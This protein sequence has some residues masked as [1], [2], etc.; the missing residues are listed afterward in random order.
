MGVTR[1]FFDMTANGSPVGRIIMELRDDVG[2]K[3]VSGPCHTRSARGAC[4]SSIAINNL[5]GWW[6]AHLPSRIQMSTP[7][8][9][10]LPEEDWWINWSTESETL[11]ASTSG[12]QLQTLSQ[13]Q[14]NRMWH[15]TGKLYHWDCWT[16]GL[17]W[18]LHQ[19]AHFSCS[20]ECCSLVAPKLSPDDDGEL[21]CPVHWREGIRVQE[22][23]IS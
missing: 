13:N 18:N 17:S 9:H 8:C 3:R 21:P 22:L 20:R 1:V 11:T 19:G 7:H 16:E 4:S 12:W 6:S 2:G 23:D 15:C 14:T 10:Q 5:G